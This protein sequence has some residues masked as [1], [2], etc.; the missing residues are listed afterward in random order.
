MATPTDLAWLAYLE[1]EAVLDHWRRRA[2][3][4][5]LFT[6]LRN[7]TVLLRRLDQP[8]AATELLGSLA[9]EAGGSAWGAEEERVAEVR[10]WVATELDADE[11][12][13]RTRRGAGR[14][15]EQAAVA[16]RVVLTGAGDG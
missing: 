12:D 3:R 14:S 16:V 7:L 15:L 2:A 4:P 1:G 9:E 11:L 8:G 5:Q 10:S 6:T 13:H